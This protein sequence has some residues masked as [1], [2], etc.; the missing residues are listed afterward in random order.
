MA[1]NSLTNMELLKQREEITETFSNVLRQLASVEITPASV[2]EALKGIKETPVSARKRLVRELTEKYVGRREPAMTVTDVE[3]A[4]QRY[5][6]ELVA[7]ENARQMDKQRAENAQLS[8][9][10]PDPQFIEVAPSN[11]APLGAQAYH[12][13]HPLPVIIDARVA[14]DKHLNPVSKYYKK[15]GERYVWWDPKTL[16]IHPEPLQYAETPSL[17]LFAHETSRIP[18]ARGAINLYSSLKRM[19]GRADYLGLTNAQF[20]KILLLW[21]E[22]HFP[23]FHAGLQMHHEAVPFFRELCSYVSIEDNRTQVQA[24]IKALTRSPGDQITRVTFMHKTLYIMM[25]EMNQSHL[26][27]EQLERKAERKVMNSI[28]QWLSEAAKKEYKSSIKVM[29]DNGDVPSFLELNDLVTTIEAIDG[30]ELQTV[31]HAGASAHKVE[32]FRMEKEREAGLNPAVTR[33]AG[34]TE[35]Q[36]L[37]R[38]GDNI[39]SPAKQGSRMF[40]GRRSRSR[41]RPGA[42]DFQR[43]QAY[44]NP[45]YESGAGQPRQRSGSGGRGSW[46]GDRNRQRNRD[47]AD[48]VYVAQTSRLSRRDQVSRQSDDEESHERDVYNVASDGSGRSTTQRQ[49]SNSWSRSAQRNSSGQRNSQPT[50]RAARRDGASGERAGG[51]RNRSASNEWGRESSRDRVLELQRLREENEELKRKYVSSAAKSSARLQTRRFQK[52]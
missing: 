51:Y 16:V 19:L 8:R 27:Y 9:P 38:W 31:K 11:I 45:R 52:N 36:S 33:S 25:E 5:E 23:H 28:E 1:V 49:R 3:I 15:D 50:G 39:T 20:Q 40:E 14:A 47:R 13:P 37:Y 41:T 32:I 22:E 18:S 7:E 24:A 10:A 4:M 2:E 17:E 30:C 34:A 29:R 46:S 21:V 35:H 12:Q 6:R 42:Q 44:Q 43:R 26:T 48:E